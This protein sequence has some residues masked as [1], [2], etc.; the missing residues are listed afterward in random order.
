[1]GFVVMLLLWG[2]HPT[3]LRPSSAAVS[4]AASRGDTAARHAL[5]AQAPEGDVALRSS[6]EP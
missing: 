4:K 1:V 5:Q 6:L 2:W 3:P